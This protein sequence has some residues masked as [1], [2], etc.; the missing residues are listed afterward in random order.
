M[1]SFTDIGFRWLYFTGDEK[2][3]LTKYCSFLLL[4]YYTSFRSCST[5]LMSRTFAGAHLNIVGT[6]PVFRDLMRV[7]PPSSWKRY[8]VSKQFW[9]KCSLHTYTFWGFGRPNLS[10]RIWSSHC[11]ATSGFFTG[12]LWKLTPLTLSFSDLLLQPGTEHAGIFCSQHKNETEAANF[13][14]SR[15][16]EWRHGQAARLLSMIENGGTQP[17]WRGISA[18]C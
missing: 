11:S 14:I 10:R 5:S 9:V 3:R 12:K 4:A 15:W 8:S 17:L 6:E 1:I 16:T 2:K 13:L 7:F 18:G